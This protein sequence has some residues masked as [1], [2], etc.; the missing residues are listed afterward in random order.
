M[1]GKTTGVFSFFFLNPQPWVKVRKSEHVE[2]GVTLHLSGDVMV[3][4]FNFHFGDRHG[5]KVITRRT[6]QTSAF[7]IRFKNRS[8]T[9]VM[10]IVTGEW[11]GIYY[12][13]EFSGITELKV[14]AI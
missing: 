13:T 14:G 11:D 9:K 6:F 3:P 1:H 12:I 8:S 5:E 2:W 4:E 10:L 7:S